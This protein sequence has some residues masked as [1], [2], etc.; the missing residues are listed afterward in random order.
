MYKPQCRRS[1]GKC[2]VMAA[3]VLL[4]VLVGLLS[5][6][7]V[8]SVLSVGSYLGWLRPRDVGQLSWPLRGV[9]GHGSPFRLRVK[10]EVNLLV[11]QLHGGHRVNGSVRINA[12]SL[13]VYCLIVKEIQG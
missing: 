11:R 6:E 9:H 4:L 7:R 2:R 5:V 13:G 1:A 3:T 8:G 12:N 10:Y